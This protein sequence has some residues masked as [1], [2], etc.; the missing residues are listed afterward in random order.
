VG[1]QLIVIVKQPDLT[2]PLEKMS[3]SAISQV[4]QKS[5]YAQ[6]EELV[7]ACKEHSHTITA[8]GFV[9]YCLNNGW[10]REVTLE[11]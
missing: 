1:E 11:V 4:F 5:Y 6:R 10:L 9:D 3:W 8:E 7:S 2:A